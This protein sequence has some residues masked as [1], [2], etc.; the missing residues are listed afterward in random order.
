MRPV[1]PIFDMKLE[2]DF[3][4][5]KIKSRFNIIFIISDYTDFAPTTN[6]ESTSMKTFKHHI[7]AVSGFFSFQLQTTPQQ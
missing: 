7:K 5:E 4:T 3:L 1:K 2:V 6:I